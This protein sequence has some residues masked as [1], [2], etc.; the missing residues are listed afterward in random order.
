VPCQAVTTTPR[1]G[2]HG[3][4]SSSAYSDIIGD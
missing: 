2:F 4:R 1:G 3:A